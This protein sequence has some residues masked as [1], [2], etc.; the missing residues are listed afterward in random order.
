MAVKAVTLVQIPWQPQVQHPQQ[1]I[2][3]SGRSRTR[4]DHLVG[5]GT[6]QRSTDLCSRL[7]TQRRTLTP[8]NDVSVCVLAYQGSTAR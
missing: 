3:R 1:P 5:I 6:I 2:N 4:E 7:L 8:V